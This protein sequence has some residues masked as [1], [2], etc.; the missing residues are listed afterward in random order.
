MKKRNSLLIV[1]VMLFIMAFTI[2]NSFATSNTNID[3]GGKLDRGVRSL[4]YYISPECEYTVSIP[5]A[6][7]NWEYPG[8]N[9]P[10][11]IY[12]VEKANSNI[13]FFQI[14]KKG[15]NYNAYAEFFLEG[16]RQLRISQLRTTDWRYGEIRLNEAN[17]G[18]RNSVDNVATIIHEIGHILGLDD[19][20]NVNSIMHFS[21]DRK[22]KTV[23]KDA[24]DAIVRKYR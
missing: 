6:I 2:K 8:W 9:N 12:S 23:T 20:N 11:N 3:L 19:I 21:A 10:I 16:G 13:D 4:G 15:A 24:N 5:K 7:K 18:R 22:P 17:M 1:L 14:Y